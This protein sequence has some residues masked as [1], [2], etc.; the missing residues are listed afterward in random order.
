MRIFAACKEL[1]ETEAA[2]SGE[3]MPYRALAAKIFGDAKGAE[4]ALA[5]V[6]GVGIRARNSEGDFPLLPARYHFFSNGIDNVTLRLSARAA[7][8][9]DDAA[10][11]SVFADDRGPRYR[12]LGCRKCGQPFLEGFLSG[13]KLEPLPPGPK[14]NRE[15]FLLPGASGGA[16]DEEDSE[17]D[18]AP[19]AIWHIDVTNGEIVGAGDSEHAIELT[20]VPLARDQDTGRQTLQKCPTCGATAGT[21]A[22]VITGFHPGDFMLGA[23][24]T[25]ALYQLMPPKK[26]E[27]HLAAGGRRLLAFSDNRQDA[28]QF[29]HTLQRTS[30]EIAVRQ[31]IMAAYQEGIGIQS[32]NALSQSVADRLSDSMMFLDEAGERYETAPDFHNY[33]RG[34]I[35]AEFCLPTG[36]RNSLEALGLVR[37]GIDRVKLRSAAELFA[38]SLPDDLKPIASDLLELLVE[39]VR[40][41]RCIT[42][43]SNV[44][45]SSEHIW[46]RNFVGNGWRFL[47]QGTSAAANFSWLPTLADTRIYHNRRSRFLLHLT[48]AQ[49]AVRI[50]SAAFGALQ[51][52]Q[53]FKQEG[54]GFVFDLKFLTLRDGREL[55]LYRCSSCGL[56]QPIGIR[57]HCAA[58][59]CEGQL[60]EIPK[61]ER[62]AEIAGGHYF[63]LYLAESYAPKMVREHTA[64]IHNNIREQIEKDFKDST[65]DLLTV[66]SCSTTMELGIDIGD[67]EAVVCRN[68]PP[69]IQN[70]QQRT[71]RAGRRAQAAPIS[72]TVARS[73]NYDQS[74]FQNVGRYLAQAPKT[75]F[76]HLLNER[77]FRRH[78]NSIILRGWLNHR[79]CTNSSGSLDFEDLFGSSFTDA[80]EEAYIGGIRDW[81]GGADAAPYLKNAGGLADGLP[82][83]LRRSQE[84]IADWFKRS[85]ASVAEWYGIRWRVYHGEWQ[86]TSNDLKLQP[87]NA[88]WG[89]QLRNWQDQLLINQLPKLGLIPSYSFPVDS[90]QLEV[91]SGAKNGR[92]W[93]NDI[94]LNRDARLGISEYAPGAEVIA[95]GRVW[96]SYGIGRYPK[97]FMA[98]RFYGSCP[99]CCH[100]EIAE[101]KDDLPSV[102]PN[103]SASLSA[104]AQ[105]AFLEP[106]SFVTSSSE[107]NGRD[108]G[109]VRLKAPMAQEARLLS[110]ASDESFF[111]ALSDVPGTSWAWQDSTQGTL[112]VVNRGRGFGYVRC[113]CG[114]AEAPRNPAQVAQIQARAHRTP[115]N[116]ECTPFWEN[117]RQ[118]EDL[119]HIY[120]TDVLQ[121]RFA[122]PVNLDGAQSADAEESFLRTLAEALRLAAARAIG[123][124]QREVGASYRLRPFHSPEI[125]LFDAVPGGA[126]YCQLLLKLGMR[127]LLEE[128][129]E[130]L[131]CSCTHSCRACLKAYENQ[132]HWD[133]LRRE[134][135]LEWIERLLAGNQSKFLGY[136]AAQVDGEL[137]AQWMPGL[138]EAG[139]ILLISPRLSRPGLAQDGGIGLARLAELIA[140][141]ALPGK[142][143]EIVLPQ[144]FGMDWSDPDAA[145][146]AKRLSPWLESGKLKLFISPPGYDPSRWPQLIVTSQRGRTCS[147]SSE[148]IFSSLLD[149]NSVGDMFRTDAD[150]I[151]DLDSMRQMWSSLSRSLFTPPTTVTMHEYQSRAPRDFSRDFQFC[152]GKNVASIQIE[153]PYALSDDFNIKSVLAIMDRIFA[154][155][156]SKPATVSLKAQFRRGMDIDGH[157]KVFLSKCKDLG[158]SGDIRL[159][160]RGPRQ[161]DFHDRRIDFELEADQ[162]KGAKEKYRVILTGGISRY[163]DT[164]CECA[165][166]IRKINS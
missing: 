71:G 20:R 136:Q 163:M 55:P 53:V 35:A 6:I 108:P 50:L 120:H 98:T 142:S 115:D 100:V 42:A 89:R 61:E 151:D 49:D 160:E 78:Q 22:E 70:Y 149:V 10:I 66:L 7:E 46:G 75:P 132:Q 150:R 103:C 31:A 116:Q 113:S 99:S 83:V 144:G 145:M 109:L 5:G 85:L 14:S 47:L 166:V 107:P 154:M 141:L 26:R 37:V 97:H 28:G 59:R 48:D 159:V 72:L 56:R 140:W 34:K 44:S 152:K 124:G 84:E 125:I 127:K 137:K 23:V 32:L 60:A 87:Q 63:Q 133:L 39:T 105:R 90:I 11:G 88:Y 119:A 73:S 41:N 25:D 12:L 126:G 92:P 164:A 38:P 147:F 64:A 156:G 122:K 121:I 62:A 36:R 65:R 94:Q 57:G 106:R 43:P 104:A 9:F 162:P 110:T 19:P 40:R 161:P 101:R 27:V 138:A 3:F 80:E 51:S 165:V 16:D 79:G 15:V 82:E 76:V 1:R 117:R 128:A 29:A 24:V 102:C 114:Y 131:R 52:S 157:K 158:C 135:V 58:F 2:L 8:G 91:H 13:T 33:I 134:P 18:T 118:P 21:D 81:L 17:Q 68:I 45:L 93:D 112:F 143:L 54:N 77:L 74:E 139:H 30:Q 69:G 67:L 4:I 95:N 148:A 123:L 130:V 155:I 86:R 111:D 96:T 153:D 146:L 129:I